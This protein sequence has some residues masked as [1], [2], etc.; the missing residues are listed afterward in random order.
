MKVKETYTGFTN[1]IHI[2]KFAFFIITDKFG[3]EINTNELVKKAVNFNY[4]VI[5]GDEPFDQKK[6]MDE[7]IKKIHK[8][9]PDTEIEI[10]TKGTIK[11]AGI[12]SMDN[13]NFVVNLQLKNANKLYE[14]RIKVN[15]LLWF[16]EMNT[17]FIFDI[18]QEDDIDE[19]LMLIIDLDIKKKSVYLYINTNK[20]QIIKHIKNKAKL[21]SVN[22][23]FN[24]D[25]LLEVKNGY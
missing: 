19:A 11:P 5:K 18:Q 20:I 21:Y 17:K 8:N 23:A 9:N 16:I 24:F 10:H 6:D 4:V 14:D 12:Q 15:E 7:F 3:I 22:Y 13:L 1:S 25:K 2:G